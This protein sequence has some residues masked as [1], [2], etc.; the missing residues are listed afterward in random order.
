MARIDF[1]TKAG[2]TL[3]VLCASLTDA[4]GTAIDLT[5]ATGVSFDM[6]LVGSSELTV[7]ATADIVGPPAN[8]DVQYAWQDGDT[9]IPGSYNASFVVTYPSGSQSF[10]SNSW[11][12]ILVQPALTDAQPATAPF[13]TAADVKAIAGQD[14]DDG[15]LAIAWSVLE[16]VSGRPLYELT[17]VETDV[18]TA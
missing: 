6:A 5:D 2:D 14:V 1:M 4:T 13:A 3:P 7:N 18:L 17:V 12:S 16:V 11:L 8:G 9:D 15:S 10:P